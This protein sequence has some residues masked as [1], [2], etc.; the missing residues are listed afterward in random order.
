MVYPMFYLDEDNYEDY[1][2]SLKEI[3]DQADNER[4]FVGSGEDA[5]IAWEKCNGQV[6]CQA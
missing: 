3:Q 6:N 1:R 5:V 4:I 2:N